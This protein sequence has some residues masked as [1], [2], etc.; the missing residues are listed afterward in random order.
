MQIK[1]LSGNNQLIQDKLEETVTILNL[2][3]TV[4]DKIRFDFLEKYDG[5]V[6]CYSNHDESKKEMMFIYPEKTSEY[7]N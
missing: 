2:D 1:N 5:F 6:A 3:S 4:D 7:N